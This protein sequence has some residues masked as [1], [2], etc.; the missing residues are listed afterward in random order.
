MKVPEHITVQV[1][2]EGE[3]DLIGIIVELK[4]TTGRKSPYHIYFPKTG[5]SGKAVLTHD[6]FIG[7]FTDHWEDGLMDHSGPP[8]SADSAVQVA[9]YDPS[10]S[11]Q[12]P[13]LAL[14]WPLLGFESTKWSSRDEQ[15][16]YRVSARN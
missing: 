1:V 3:A 9:L 6:D 7:Q 16:Q 4:V 12:N 13:K 10:W 14:A 5:Q 2:C 8:E 11:I 15:Y